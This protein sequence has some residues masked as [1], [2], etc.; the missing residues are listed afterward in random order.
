MPK[1]YV[2]LSLNVSP[3][4]RK[5]VHALARNRG[6]KIT[7]DYLRWLIETDAKA[8]DIDFAFTLDRGGY[9]TRSDKTK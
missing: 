9:R 5:Q 2:P 7:S 4:E 8:Q 3:E 6:Y 1:Q